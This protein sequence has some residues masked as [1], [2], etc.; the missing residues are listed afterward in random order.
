MKKYMGLI[1][2]EDL[3]KIFTMKPSE[4]EISDSVKS[5]DKKT[6]E[7]WQNFNDAVKRIVCKL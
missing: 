2:M 1:L 7:N 6:A 5:Y 3:S 4:F